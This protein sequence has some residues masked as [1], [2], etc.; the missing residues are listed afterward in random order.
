MARQTLGVT[1]LK[2][3]LKNNSSTGGQLPMNKS[4]STLPKEVSEENRQMSVWQQKPLQLKDKSSQ[5]NRKHKTN[6]IQQA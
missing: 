1:A 3:K 6:Q 2:T 5:I 4:T